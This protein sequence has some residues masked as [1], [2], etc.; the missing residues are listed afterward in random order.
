MNN[1]INHNN[2]VL[3]ALTLYIEQD[4]QYRILNP[5]IAANDRHS[6]LMKMQTLENIALHFRKTKL[7]GE[8]LSLSFIKSE[9][10]KIKVQI[11]PSVLN[12][13]LNGGFARFLSNVF[14]RT[15]EN[16]R[17]HTNYVDSFQREVG[18]TQN[19]LQLSEALKKNGFHQNVDLSLSKSIK[20][21]LPS[22]SIRYYDVKA[23][24]V[25]YI[26]HFNKI[27]ETNAYQFKKFETSSRISKFDTSSAKSHWYTFKLDTK[28]SFNAKEA[29]LLTAGK[30]ICK[31]E[32]DWYYLTLN[33]IQSCKF[34]IESKLRELPIQDLSLMAFNNIV[35]GVKNGFTKELSITVDGHIEKFYVIASPINDVLVIKDKHN[36]FIDK[37]WLNEVVKIGNKNAKDLIKVSESKKEIKTNNT[38]KIVR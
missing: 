17:W 37:H 31:G 23:P 19:L 6:L 13:L 1:N 24:E 5:I 34:D 15:F 10:R 28:V 12:Y 33:G 4:T 32:D 36:N 30:S 22:F 14:G 9:I 16:N 38:A 3:D 2:R 35:N 25:N 27:P 11:T 20:Q 29:A 26:L 8:K 18:E 21:G 7:D